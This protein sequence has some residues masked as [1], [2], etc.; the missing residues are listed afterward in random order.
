MT[1]CRQQA[2]GLVVPQTLLYTAASSVAH[3][4]I[5]TPTHTGNTLCKAKQAR[6][7][8]LAHL[9]Q[10]GV[11][12][13]SARWQQSLSMQC[14]PATKTEVMGRPPLH[15]SYG[16]HQL[17]RLGCAVPCQGHQRDRP[18]GGLPLAT[19]GAVQDCCRDDGGAEVEG[20]IVL[21]GARH[22]GQRLSHRLLL[23]LQA[24]GHRSVAEL[25][26]FGHGSLG[27]RL[28]L[29]LQTTQ[30][31]VHQLQEAGWWCRDVTVRVTCH[32]GQPL[33]SGVLRCSSEEARPQQGE[34]IGR[35]HPAVCPTSGRET[36][37]SQTVPTSASSPSP[38]AQPSL[39]RN[40]FRQRTAEMAAVSWCSTLSTLAWTSTRE[41]IC[42]PAAIQGSFGEGSPGLMQ[43][44]SAGL[45]TT[46]AGTRPSTGQAPAG[47]LL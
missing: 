23:V 5:H 38:K 2:V 22:D 40:S 39:S 43:S 10:V 7:A 1:N 41:S 26:C 45:Q 15:S 14:L 21:Q 44:K 19:P 36:D 35:H 18:E 24:Q 16:G 12:P 27:C 28:L 4:H 20:G 17:S 47:K 32:H 33:G 37:S 42:R 8:P 31:D 11:S 25:Q 29:A 3:T 34:H 6:S 9:V 46:G 13:C 30:R